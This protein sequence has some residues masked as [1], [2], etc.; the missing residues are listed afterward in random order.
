MKR[1][2]KSPLIVDRLDAAGNTPFIPAER[3]QE[4]P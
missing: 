4:Y 1:A 2:A 3:L